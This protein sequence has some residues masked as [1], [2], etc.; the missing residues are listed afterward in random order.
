[1]N[2]KI[3]YDI[4]DAAHGTLDIV[5]LDITMCISKCSGAT[6]NGPLTT[7]GPGRESNP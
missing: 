6:H 3:F 1:M 4:S 2:I 7:R 5:V